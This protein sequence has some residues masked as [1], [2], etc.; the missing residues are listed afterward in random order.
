MAL[1]FITTGQKL[2]TAKKAIDKT[3]KNNGSRLFWQDMFD[4][5]KVKMPL[6]FKRTTAYMLMKIGKYPPLRNVHHAEQLPP[7]WT[8]LHQLTRLSP[9]EFEKHLKAGDIHPDLDRKDIA[10]WI[11][12]KKKK[13]KNNP[14]ELLPGRDIWP[15]ELSC[16]HEVENILRQ[17]YFTLDKDAQSQ[18][19]DFIR[20]LLENL[21]KEAGNQLASIT[22]YKKILNVR[23]L[24]ETPLTDPGGPG[25]GMGRG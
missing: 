19:S 17:T 1:V 6:R 8:H 15:P 18:L 21:L 11:L 9:P 14:G 7:N 2:I 13:K 22:S 3:R 16:L 20:S 5:K 23:S 25:K 24:D 12:K 4:K 10:K